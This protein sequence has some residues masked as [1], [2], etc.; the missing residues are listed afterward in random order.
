MV[1]RGGAVTENH[2]ARMRRE[3]EQAQL[4]V[5]T[6]AVTESVQPRQ[7][8]GVSDSADTPEQD[9]VRRVITRLSDEGQGLAEHEQRALAKALVAD[10][11]GNLAR[12]QME[13]IEHEILMTLGGR[14]GVLQPLMDD[15]SVTEIMVNGP[16]QVFVERAGRIELT[17]I[18]FR[19][20]PAVQALVERIVSPLGRSF[21]VAHPT[22]DARL[23]DGSRVNAVRPPVS[24]LGTVLTIRRFP[25]PFSLEELVEAGA[26]GSA[27]AYGMPKEL[28]G[29]YPHGA[30]A[31]VVLAWCVHNGANL[32][33][34]GGT[35]SG[36][37]TVL[38]ALS[39]FIPITH[40]TVYIE[41]A[42]ELQPRQP[43]V[44]RLEA[45]PANTEGAGSVTIQHLVVNALRMRPDR[46]IVGEFRG[47]EA[48]DMLV[49][50]NTGHDGSLS[51]AHAN[52]P[53]ELFDRLVQ[54]TTLSGTTHANEQT[55]IRIAAQAIKVVVQV[56][57][58]RGRRRFDSITAVSGVDEQG[59]SRLTE[60]F[61]W[62]GDAMVSTHQAPPWVRAD[63]S[64]R[65]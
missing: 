36:K 40:R 12:P 22:V 59:V 58:H 29:P 14:L 46:I 1:G 11:A 61:R 60:L 5:G 62:D 48:L 4:Q 34:S 54:A 51:T 7:F 56:V 21:S 24:L 41:D 38:N 35:G 31:W 10:E 20:D 39:A 27:M 64:L 19:N 28:A 53:L 3:R 18:T 52:S 8:L 32:I 49:A 15:P 30:P 47:A 26:F 42:A 13:A 17:D 50:M 44:V 43:H 63:G 55:I 37:T 25:R 6:L 65:T 33:V 16:K 45:R 2:L 9:A 57:R 23:P